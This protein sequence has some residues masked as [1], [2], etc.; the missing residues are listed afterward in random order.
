MITKLP[1]KVLDGKL[2][3]MDELDLRIRNIEAVIQDIRID[4]IE[5]RTEVKEEDIKRIEKLNKY[6][7]V[8]DS[9]WGAKSSKASAV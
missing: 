2:S 6:Q 5:M 3:K 9:L 7:N 8:I 1:V 4:L